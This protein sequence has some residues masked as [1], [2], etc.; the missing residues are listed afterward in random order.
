M[1]N[2]TPLS[3]FLGG[4]LIGLSSLGA[5]FILGR[6]AGVSGIAEQALFIWQKAD[7]RFWAVWFLLGL[8][9][10]GEI[11]YLM[12]YPAFGNGHPHNIELIGIGGLLVGFGSRM[13]A[14]CTSG[15]GVC[16]LGRLSFRSLV[17]VLTFMFSAFV[18]LLIKR[19]LF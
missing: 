3:S 15:H 8:V 7:N 9:I 16:G 6:I 19:Y 18:T 2:F 14:G 5:L 13:G 11:I 17:A 4:I 10:G 12:G 1:E